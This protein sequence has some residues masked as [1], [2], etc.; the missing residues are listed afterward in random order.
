VA[1]AY[2]QALAT[3]ADAAKPEPVRSGAFGIL[4]EVARPDSIP[5]MLQLLGGTQPDRIRAGALDVL[6]KFDDAAVAPAVLDRYASLSPPVKAKA[7]DILLSRPSSARALITLVD[8]GRM[9][10]QE[11]PVTQLRRIDAY[12]DP[13]LHALVRKHWGAI[14]QGSAEEKL[15]EVRRLNNDLRAGTGDARSGQRLFLRQC[16]ACHQL[17]GAGGDLGM[18]LT[19][20]NRTDRMYLLTH[21]VDPGVFIRKEYMSHQVGTRSG[22]VVT[23][24]IVEQDASALT[25]VDANLQRTRIPRSDVASMEESEASLMPENLLSGLKPQELRDLFAYLQKQ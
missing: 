20:A 16:G 22:R 25:I 2:R 18:D 1:E 9:P 14:G 15:A 21:I 11:I 6:A 19:A 12:E 3:A 13:A 8:S 7:R 17:F 5:V 23:G 24:L 10:A 4:T